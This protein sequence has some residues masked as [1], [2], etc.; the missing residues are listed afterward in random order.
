MF[1]NS[2][3]DRSILIE[4][5]SYLYFGG[6]SYLG[7][8]THPEFQEQLYRSFQQWGTSYG[9]SR[10]SNIQLSI[11]EHAEN[12]LANHLGAEAALT[13]SSGTLAGQLVLETLEQVTDRFFHYPKTHPAILHKDSQ[14]IVKDGSLHPDLNTTKSES[15][16]ITLDAVLAGEIQKTDLHLIKTIAATKKITLLIDESHSICLIGAHKW[17][18]FGQ[19]NTDNLERK[20][21]TASLSKAFSCVGGLIASD[22]VFIEKLRMQSLFVGSSPMNPAYLSTLLNS[23]DH[24]LNKQK[25]LDNNLNFLHKKLEPNHIIKFSRDYPVIYVKGN[26]IYDRLKL[27]GLIISSFKYPGYDSVMNRVVITA[28]HHKD[29][30][31]LLAASL[32]KL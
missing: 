18:I 31:S 26:D 11:F 6:T 14:P 24:V 32:N 3:P 16:A 20:I 19:I 25:M 27:D 22:K 13:I 5:Q 8:A 10:A 9:S 23:Q 4:G 30:L 12:D 28:N 15:I 21:V 2:F 7:L 17:G 29:D 1:V